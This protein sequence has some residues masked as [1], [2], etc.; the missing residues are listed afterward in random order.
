LTTLVVGASGA[1]G[2]LVVEQLLNLGQKVKVIVRSM[3]RLPESLTANSQLTVTEA[4]LLDMTD[5]DL[6]AQVKGCYAVIS[7]LGHNLT[8]RGM[9]GQPRRLVSNA[10]ERLCDAIKATKLETPIRFVLMNTAGNQNLQ[11]GETVSK[12]QNF[13]VGMIRHLIPPHA[14]NEAAA[15]YLQTHYGNNQ[16]VIEWVTVRP[17]SLINEVSV[18][19]YKVHP[20]PTRSAIF[21]AGITSRIN[22]A[23]FMSQLVTN[24]STW[25]KWERQMPVIYNALQS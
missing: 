8:L 7:C 21:D 12:A 14:D 6:Q 11:A 1:T 18:T 3:D 5:S 2:I 22:V 24:D 9:Y 17:D 10:V 23:S 13:I 19:E 4:T 20:A 25:Q 15:A 16:K